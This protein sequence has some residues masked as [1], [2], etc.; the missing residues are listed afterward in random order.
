[1]VRGAVLSLCASFG[2]GMERQSWCIYGYFDQLSVFFFFHTVMSWVLT[3]NTIRQMCYSLGN[4]AV[5][6]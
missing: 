1:M 5:A 4:A 3:E 2:L 6:V